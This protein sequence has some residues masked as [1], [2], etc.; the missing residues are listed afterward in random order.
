MRWV[1]PDLPVREAQRRQA[2]GNVRVVAVMVPGLLLRRPV[3]SKPVR[4]DDE[5]QI[6]PIEVDLE[7]IHPLLGERR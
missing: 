5:A 6:G 4:L 3:I 1:V 2:S 7:A